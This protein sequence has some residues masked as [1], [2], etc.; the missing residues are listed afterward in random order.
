MFIH[1]DLLVVE[2]ENELFIVAFKNIIDKTK[3]SDIIKINGIEFDFGKFSLELTFYL[4]KQ[5]PFVF[6]LDFDFLLTDVMSV[7]LSTNIDDFLGKVH[8]NKWIIIRLN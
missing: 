5:V 6:E 1:L 8:Q 7:R 2:I 3:T 4:H